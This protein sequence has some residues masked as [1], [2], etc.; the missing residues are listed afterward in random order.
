[1]PKHFKILITLILGSVTFGFAQEEGEDIGTQ[2]V[3]VV[4]AY[5]PTISDAFK[6]KETPT[7]ND[8]V[9]TQK[10]EIEYSIYSVPVASTFTPAK[11]KAEV[12]QKAKKEKLYNSYA[13]LAVGN[14]S[15][16]M[17]DLYTS[18]SINRNETLDIGLNHHS[19]QGGIEGA[20]LDDSFF[21]TKL[22]GAYA[23]RNRDLEWGANAGFQHQI[24]N[25]YGLS[26]DLFPDESIFTGKE[27]Q[28][29]YN[30]FGGMRLEMKDSFFKGGEFLLRRFW[31]SFE[32][33][34][35]RVIITPEMELP[36]ADELVLLGVKADYIG[37]EFARNYLTSDPLKYSNFQIGVSPSLV[38][39]RDNLTL[40]L[41]ASF[42]Y[43]ID[44]EGSDGNFFIYPKV[45]ASYRL[46]DEYVI[47]YGGIEGALKH[48][49]FYEFT[50][51]NPFVSP[52]LNIVPTDRQYDAYV[53][54]KGKL[55]SNLSYN[56][57]G[58]YIAENNKALFR[59]NT[60]NNIAE[61]ALGYTYANSFGMVYDDVK[62][63][64]VFGE[65]NVDINRN[66]SLG[67]NLEIFDY[68]MDKEQEAWNLPAVK[69]SL[70]ADYQIDENWFMGA[71]LF[72]TGKRYDLLTNIDL[73]VAPQILELESYFD[74][75][76]HLGYRFN[77]QLSAFLK[78]N[79]IANNNY[80][81]WAHYNVMG[82][83][84]MA[85]AT[86]KFDF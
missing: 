55:L 58:S 51:E 50:K 73:L 31:N 36:I 19:S 64:S 1:M 81:R 38:V 85:G 80:A 54:I 30:A 69:G 52:T 17:M 63:L 82:F 47:A 75:N 15:S 45:T 61:P 43:G 12:V 59:L 66:F 7:L 8:S 10:K 60:P 35:N 57:R 70:L 78:L 44:I 11:G 26:E 4:K 9:T 24:Y 46:I 40:N 37:G 49:S 22:E 5:T 34:E 56:L 42:V 67:V 13:S 3:N 2:V 27:K 16:L 39:L 79:N 21:N 84:V 62:T 41:G 65:L 48:N 14:F 71:N 83:Q 68:N 86:Y 33:G 53:G 25:W 32:S 76:A 72:Y 6:V 18:R 23:N 29:Y 28:T 77:D 20:R 74:A